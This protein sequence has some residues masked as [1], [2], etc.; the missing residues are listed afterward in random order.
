MMHDDQQA[1]GQEMTR[2]GVGSSGSNAAES[3]GGTG[4]GETPS[5]ARSSGRRRRGNRRTRGALSKEGLL[6]PGAI[7]SLILMFVLVA[8]VIRMPLTASGRTAAYEYALLDGLTDVVHVVHRWY[9]AEPDF[10]EMREGAIRGMLDSLDD[11]YT[12]F[13]SVEQIEEFDKQIRGNYVGIGAEVN[14]HRSG[15][16]AIISPMDDSPALMAGLQAG[17]LIVAVDGRSTYQLGTTNV[18]TLLKGEPGTEVV[19]TVER[20]AEERPAGAEPPSVA[21]KTK[22]APAEH[23]IPPAVP[24]D[25]AQVFLDDP[26]TAPGPPPGSVRFDLRIT[27]ERIQ[28]Q[29]VRGL[30]R[31]ADEW[32][33]FVDPVERI[34]Y[35]RVSQFTEET[36]RVFPQVMAQL[37][38]EGMEGLVLDLRYNSGG[39]FEAAARMADLLLDDGVIVST[40]GRNVPEE[41][42]YAREQG[43][44]PEFAIAVLV[45]GAS[46]SASEIVAGALADNGR[47][48]V[49]GER[50]FG[51][52]LVQRIESLPS[53]AGRVK[54]TIARYYLPSGRHI[55]REDD[56]TEWGVDPTPGFY[57]PLSN[58][59][60]IEVWTTRR[61]EEILRP[62][63]DENAGRWQDPAWVLD[64]L[65]DPPLTRAVEAIRAKLSTGSWPEPTD[66]VEDDRAIDLAAV[67]ALREQ[68]E[69]LLRALEQN[70]SRIEALRDVEGAD[71]Q[72]ASDLWTDEV[73]LTGGRLIVRDAEGEV[74]AELDIT[75]ENLERWLMDAPV[76]PARAEPAGSAAGTD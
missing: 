47:A 32:L 74:V 41:T 53:G 29:T 40:R 76:E 42:V 16:M 12:E 1:E 14:D 24:G 44:L 28:T 10:L 20:E 72:E 26:I 62:K 4:G 2:T 75:G 8:L 68:R 9:Y 39:A 27:R 18:I 49:V 13:I 50:T 59:E 73:S 64:R 21:G 58:D 70:E 37:L 69:R 7:P 71:R 67:R 43:T 36:A 5:E 31:N 19:V 15:F 63:E 23:T 46:A 48:I 17:D 30:H 51:K 11:D 55:Q 60:Q 56:S 66:A 22:L 6:A 65:G 57:V 61:D 35:V 25:E 38:D 3:G 54:I 33:W 45:N 52:G 34:A